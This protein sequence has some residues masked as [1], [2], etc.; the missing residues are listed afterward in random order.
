[1]YEKIANAAYKELNLNAQ[2]KRSVDAI[3]HSFFLYG[4]GDVRKLAYI[5]ATAKH[6][7]NLTPIKEIKGNEGTPLWNIQRK[8]WDTGY[9]GRGFVQITWKKNYEKL[10]D[11]LGVNLVDFPDKALNTNIAADIIVIG[12]VKGL[13]TGKKLLQYLNDDSD[14]MYHARKTVGAINV[15]G[16]DTAARI[17]GFARKILA[18]VDLTKPVDVVEADGSNVIFI[19]VV[20]S[21]FLYAL[22]KLL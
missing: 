14:D 19:V 2:Q 11:V 5:I 4:D 10:G 8:Y 13:F 3:C 1:M 12:M 20:V 16:M 17:E 18:D 7:S 9:Y 15:L 22:K 21:A 6:E